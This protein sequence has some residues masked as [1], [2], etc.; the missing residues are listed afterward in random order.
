MVVE[1]PR[2]FS[3]L[4]T[5]SSPLSPLNPAP[6]DLPTILDFFDHHAWTATSTS[7]SSFIFVLSPTSPL[8]F[9]LSMA[10]PLRSAASQLPARTPRA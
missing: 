8:R 2:P 4:T 6:V 7:P 9:L 10:E 1:R 3:R 5:S